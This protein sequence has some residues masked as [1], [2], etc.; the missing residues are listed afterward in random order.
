M[1]ITKWKP[2]SCIKAD[3]NIAAKVFEE[4]SE[5]VGL[6]PESLLDASRDEDAPL[7]KEFEWD[8]SVAAEKYRVTQAGHLIRSIVIQTV[9]ESDEE[10]PTII[11]AY[12][13]AGSDEYEPIRV[14]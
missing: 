6:T 11:R 12:M 14:L 1:F 4:L 3:P 8:D 5:S 2:G 7:H 10:K 13:H 9:P